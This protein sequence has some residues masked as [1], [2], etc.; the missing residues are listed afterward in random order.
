MRLKNEYGCILTIKNI[1]TPK[2]TLRERD[3]KVN[4]FSLLLLQETC[5][6]KK[7]KILLI[8]QV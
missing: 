2:G 6:V 1:P 5:E 8:N 4:V 3:Y 7:K